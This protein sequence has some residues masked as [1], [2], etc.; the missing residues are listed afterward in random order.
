MF[1]PKL[2]RTLYRLRKTRSINVGSSSFISIPEFVNNDYNTNH[3]DLFESNSFDY[4]PNISN[5]QL[6]ESEQMENNIGYVVPT[7][8]PQLE[9][10]QSYKLKSRL[11]HLLS[12]FH[13]LASEDPHKHLKEFHMVCSTMRSHGMLEDY[14]KMKVFPFSLGDMKCI[15]LEKFFSAS[16][17][18]TIRKESYGIRQHLGEILHEFNKLCATCPHHQISEQLLLQY[19]YEGLMMMG[20]NM[21]DDVSSGALVDKTPART[22]HLISN[23][24]SNTSCHILSGERSWHNRQLEVGESADRVDITS[25]AARCRTASVERTSKSLWNMYLSGASNRYVPHIAGNRAQ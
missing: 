23:M 22:R 1:D 16:K 15:F 17:I 3:S 19:F 4:K 14:I 11:I 13:G 25:E 20:R 18:E 21:I 12:K 5:N 2:D 8:Y 6:Y 9:P 24:A 10:T 7:M